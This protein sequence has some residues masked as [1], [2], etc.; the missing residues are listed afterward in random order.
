MRGGGAPARLGAA[1]LG[2]D[3]RLFGVRR[4][5][6]DGAEAL[7]VLDAFEIAD[8][9]VGAARIGQPVK[10]IVRF[11]ANLVAGAGLVGKA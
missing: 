7:R 11:E 6:G 5:F 8:E 4:L 10:V 2:E 1:D 9:D 3:H